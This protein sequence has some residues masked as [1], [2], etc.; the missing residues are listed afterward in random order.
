[1]PTVRIQ[2]LPKNLQVKFRRAVALSGCSQ[3]AW[4]SAAIRRFI[5]EQEE[6]H[7]NLLFV[8]TPDEQDAIK[9]I[10]SGCAEAQQIAQEITLSHKR[11]E[12]VLADLVERGILEI[13]RKGG[14]T[15][16]ARGAVTKL[17]FVSSKY[18]PHS[19]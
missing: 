13:R 4:L 3:S 5:R 9:A 15:E 12:A 6:K 18:Q 1:M 2:S 16:Q 19:K 7:G 11:T 10:N 8:L 14:K 17:Y